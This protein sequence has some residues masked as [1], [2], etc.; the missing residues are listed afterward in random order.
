MS[1]TKTTNLG[2]ITINTNVI[3][4]EILA[5]TAKVNEKLFLSTEK[6]K[7]LGTPKKVGSGELS[8][9][10]YVKEEDG[11]FSLTFYIVMNFGSSIK[12]TTEIVLDALETS[13]KA[14]FPRQD[15]VITIKI[16]GV[17]SKNIAPRDIEVTREYEASRQ[18]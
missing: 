15:G 8:S 10:I 6:H 13:F 2:T 3:S 7:I 11:L 16:V 12:N 14:M 1:L 17:K 5:A 9:N 18:G 4:R